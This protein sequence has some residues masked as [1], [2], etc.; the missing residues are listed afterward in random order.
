MSVLRRLLNRVDRRLDR[1]SLH[2]AEE[3]A[4]RWPGGGVPCL[5]SHALERAVAVAQ[6]LERDVRLKRIAAPEGTAIDGAARRW[7][8]ALELPRRRAKL[9]CDWYLDGDARYGR[10]GRE[11]LD[12]RAAP[13]PAPDSA[14]ARGVE[15]GRFGYASLGA[16]WRQERRRQPDLPLV[17]HDSDVTLADLQARGFRP[18]EAGFVLQ[19]A[20][21][22]GHGN[23]WL[24]EA[25]ERNFR[26]RFA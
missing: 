17:F 5:A 26:C 2:A 16:A 3:G 14:I 20:C 19:S 18:A 9:R 24:V 25:G 4:E 7:S 10:F 12:W 13:F 23:V 1:G 6:R 21:L 8:L 15:E 11:C 22:A